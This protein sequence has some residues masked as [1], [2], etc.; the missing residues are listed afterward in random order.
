MLVDSLIVNWKGTYLIDEQ[1]VPCDEIR[2]NIILQSQLSGCVSLAHPFPR[3]FNR[4]E[5]Q[6]AWIDGPCNELRDSAYA[7]YWRQAE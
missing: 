2:I 1:S 5:N 6:D 7:L 3:I 4:S